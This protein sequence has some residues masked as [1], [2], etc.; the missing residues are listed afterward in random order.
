VSKIR[1]ISAVSSRF[2]P[3]LAVAICDVA[4]LSLHGLTKLT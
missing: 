4:R 1:G 3:L 2:T